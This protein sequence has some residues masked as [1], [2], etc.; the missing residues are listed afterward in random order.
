MKEAIGN[1]ALF[2][3]IITF[4]VIMIMFFVGSLSYSKAFKVKNKI[5]EEI[6][7]EGEVPGADP[8]TAYSRAEGAI[9]EWLKAGGENGTGIGYRQNTGGLN[10]HLNCTE[11]EGT[12]VSKGGDYQYCVYQIDTCAGG[13]EGRCGVYYRVTAYMF[14]DIPVI[15]ELLKIPVSG[16]T[17]IFT[18][19]ES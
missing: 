18:K 13:R 16:E 12:V 4:V 19:L 17:M 5:V 14:F 3:I 2:Y 10:N 8:Y 1:A 15:G 11:G 6:E 9:Y 7:K